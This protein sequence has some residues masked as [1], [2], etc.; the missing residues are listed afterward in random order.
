M[1]GRKFGISGSHVIQE[2]TFSLD[3]VNELFVD[4][5]IA[6]VQLVTHEENYA[7]II[8]E[9]YEK[10]P[11]LDVSLENDRLIVFVEDRKRK[12][13]FNFRTSNYCTLYIYIPKGNLLNYQMLTGAGDVTISNIEGSVLFLKTGAGNVTMETVTMKRIK[14]SSGAGNVTLNHVHADHMTF[15]SGAGRIVGF[16]CK[17]KISAESGAGNINITIDG[18]DDVSLSTG[19]GNIEVTLPEIETLDAT[20]DISSGIGRV[21][22]DFVS[23][24]GKSTQVFNNGTNRLTFKTGAGNIYLKGASN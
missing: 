21:N 16:D 3:Q 11:D 10:G 20:I 6:N 2:D 17:G 18:E 5:E 12:R 24:G 13:F 9:T 4:A 1:M 8:L 23:L 19:V 14:L 15:S 7:K 22:S